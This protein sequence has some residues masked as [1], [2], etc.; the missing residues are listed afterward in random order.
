[1]QL[2][3]GMVCFISPVLSCAA[4]PPTYPLHL[5][6]R[7][8]PGP[9]GE[10]TIEEDAA[11]TKAR[12][13]REE[14]ARRA[15][16]ERKKSQALQRGL[17]RPTSLAQ[18]S[19]VRPGGAAA[20]L[21]ERA[22]QLLVQELVV[23]LQHDNDK[24]PI[25]RSKK[26][27]GGCS[28]A[29]AVL[30]EYLL[31]LL[32]ASSGALLPRVIT[33]ANTILSS[34]EMHPQYEAVTETRCLA[35]SSVVGKQQAVSAPRTPPLPQLPEQHL[36]EARLLLEEE[37]ETV[38]WGLGCCTAGWV[39]RCPSVASCHLAPGTRGPCLARITGHT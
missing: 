36:Q 23:L 37:L 3:L 16:E 4:V 7:P 17:P 18:L 22:E 2:V 1:M 34:E 38:R 26:D 6:K 28:A 29:P 5:L 24:Y 35:C 10:E 39:L 32:H 11:E 15:A 31:C 27:K 30:A 14:E 20:G 19:D 13:L 33:K 25:K 21:R 9:A 12:R 8:L